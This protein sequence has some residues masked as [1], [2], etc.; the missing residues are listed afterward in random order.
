[1]DSFVIYARKGV[2]MNQFQIV[3]LVIISVIVAVA[4]MV[5]K[6]N[7]PEEIETSCITKPFYRV[8]TWLLRII[9]GGER[10]HPF[11]KA[12]QKRIF[13]RNEENIG[14]LEPAA[15]RVRVSSIHFVKKT[16]MCIL[17]LFVGCTLAMLL[18]M[19]EEKKS[20]LVNAYDL[21]REEGT[22]E[23]YTVELTAV[24][25]AE[26]LEKVPVHVAEREYTQEEIDSILPEFRETLE[27]TVLSDNDSA[28]HVDKDMNL[29]ETVDGYPFVVH[30]EM[31]HTGILDRHGTLEDGIDAKGVLVMLTATI[32]YLDYAEE[33]SFPVMV[34][35]RALTVQ[36]EYRLA[37]DGAISEQARESAREPYFSLPDSVNGVKVVWQEEKKRN[38]VFLFGLILAAGI[39]IYVGADRDL[40]QLV[41]K[42]NQEMIADYPEMVSKLAL[43]VGAGMT[44]RN[45]WRKMAMDYQ[46]ARN[47]GQKKHYVYE[48]MLYTMYEMESG[49]GEMRSYQN[50]ATRCRVQRYVK[51]IALLEQ[52][53]K[54]GA[55]GFLESL[56]EEARDALQD[57]KS[58]ARKL[59]EEAGTKLLV[60]MIL[61]LL[62]VMVVIM[63]PA[64]MTI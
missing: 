20:I 23:D 49:T 17:L 63:V 5:R 60:P 58:N 12:L 28:N 62:I 21:K 26:V 36:E 13:T 9:R 27:M 19:K 18:S 44:V 31:D 37:L 47:A 30:W 3:M 57:Q 46:N 38:A 64:F 54:M 53:V 10:G 15:N 56:Q 14:L 40:D 16:G 48:E 33:Y 7:V 55:R 22:G 51:L 25:D 43:L 39:V 50:F 35:P 42:R 1:M 4:I 34:Y 11:Q 24:V 8:A 29:V 45:A 59:G 61:M 2:S 6:E 41:K 32:T 52:N